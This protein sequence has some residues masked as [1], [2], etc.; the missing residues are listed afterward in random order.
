[1]LELFRSLKQNRRLLRS[2]VVRDL[3][4]RYVGSMMGFFWSVIF[5]LINLTIYAFVFRLILRMRWSDQQGQNEV[6]LL[7][8][9]GIVVW[10]AFAETISRSTNTLVENS[11]LIQKI[12][13]PSELLPV[14]LATSSLVNMCIALPFV[15]MGVAWYG[16]LHPQM[17]PTTP[18]APGDPAYMPLSFGWALV[19]LPVLLALQMMLA[20]GLGYFLAALNLFVRDTIHLIGVFLTVWMFATPIFYP[21]AMV[22]KNGYGWVLAANPMNWLVDAYRSVLVYGAWPDFA[23]LAR[24]ALVAAVVL[25]LGVSFFMK[26]KSRFPD[27]L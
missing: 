6:V 1:V 7:M 21:P 15:L 2:F 20:L 18:P 17:V 4:G 12:K 14:Y 27:L 19:I 5:P 10:T 23:L 8:F 24:F 22:T 3:K 9:A 26:H 13:F 11:N 16:Y 25:M